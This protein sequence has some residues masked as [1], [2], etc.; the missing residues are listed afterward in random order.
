MDRSDRASSR[1][2]LWLRRFCTLF[3][4][5]TLIAETIYVPVFADFGLTQFNVNNTT[6]SSYSFNPGA[7]FSMDIATTNTLSSAITN[8]YIYVNFGNNNG[9]SYT[10]A[11]ERSRIYGST[12]TSPIPT[13]AYSTG[14]GIAYQ[15]TTSGTPSIAASQTFSFSRMSNNFNAF[16]VSP[17]ISTYANNVTAWFAGTNASGSVVTGASSSAIFYANVRPH[18]TSYGF[19]DANT[20]QSISSVQGG[21]NQAFNLVL[22]VKDYNGCA[23]IS[24][25][26]VRANLSQLGL[27]TSE[28]LAYV[29][30]NSDGKTAVFQETNITTLAATGSYTFNGSHFTATDADG[31]VNALTDSNTSF[32]SED[33]N[34]NTTL[35]VTS[36]ST[37]SVS[38]LSV[39][40]S[41]IG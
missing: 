6:S 12:I 15:I 35:T 36:A 32:S 17:N 24:N 39:G 11:D 20:L 33:L 21:G 22:N 30:C 31:N 7:T 28:H 3:L 1:C 8:A 38:I 2:L 34:T 37:P 29:S 23:N 41:I 4:I 5:G 9:F 13:S 10:G 14:A 18:V 19:V 25:G 26:T 40:N 16:T 27:S